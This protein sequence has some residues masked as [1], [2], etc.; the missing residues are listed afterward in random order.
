[1]IVGF[2]QEDVTPQGYTL[3]PGKRGY[4]EILP[5]YLGSLSDKM[6]QAYVVLKDGEELG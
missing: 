3:F 6:E 1:M 5:G 4:Q 2:F